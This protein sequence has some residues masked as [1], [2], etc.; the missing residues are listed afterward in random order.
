[1]NA[2]PRNELFEL[3]IT[4]PDAHLA[5]TA[6]TLVGFDARFERLGRSLVAL[7]E[8]DSVTSWASKFH[9]RDLPVATIL[10]QRYPLVL[11]EGD[12]GTG[13]TAFAEC[14]AD[15]LARATRR[16]GRLLKLS[17]RVRGQGH[18]GQMSHLINAAFA[19]VEQEAGRKRLAFLLIDE[20][21]SLAASREGD[22]SHHEDKVAVNTLIQKIDDIRRLGGRVLVF[23]STNRPGALDPALIRRAGG[24]EQFDRPDAAERVALLRHDTRGL[25]IS[26]Q[27]LD[28]LAAITGPNH[29][30]QGPGFT[31][32]DLRTRLLPEAVLRAFP[33]RPLTDADL[34]AVAESMEPSPALV[35]A[36]VTR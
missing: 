30:H 34:V 26:P 20:A 10:S 21:D 9:G 23:L 36:D 8:P 22:R 5:T 16:E 25:G 2:T 24:R 17:T 33:D 13:K 6:E 35:A 12:V 18:V 29:H 14:A 31:F 7:L 4:L 3:D 28:R 32:S 27:A 15:R 19:A 11:L 1:V